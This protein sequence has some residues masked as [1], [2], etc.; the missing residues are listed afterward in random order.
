M[1][2]Q[3]VRAKV[4]Q[5]GPDAKPVLRRLLEFNAYELSAVDGRDL[6]PEGEYGY[7]YLDHYWDGSPGRAA[8]A[9]RVGGHL[10]VCALLRQGPPHQVADSLVLPSYRHSGVG[11]RAA[12]RAADPHVIHS[13]HWMRAG[14]AVLCQSASSQ[15]YSWHARSMN[16][17]VP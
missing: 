16:R 6:G 2:A 8:F 11:Q 1:D 10:A 3:L 9:F 4:E 13:R 12:P 7:T 5:A 14:C 15:P 17:W